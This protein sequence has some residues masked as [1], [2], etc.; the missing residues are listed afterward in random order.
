MIALV[1]HCFVTDM[2]NNLNEAFCAG[3]QFDFRS[4]YCLSL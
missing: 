4:A 2:K 1:L 3:A